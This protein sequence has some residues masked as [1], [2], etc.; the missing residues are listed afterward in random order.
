MTSESLRWI[1][2]EDSGGTAK[3]KDGKLNPTWNTSFRRA[4]KSLESRGRIGIVSR[5]LVSFEECVAHYPNKTLQV[6]ARNLRSDF[7]PVLQEWIDAEDGITPKYGTAANEEHHLK[8]LPKNE[9]DM[10]VRDWMNLEESI[11]P[12]YGSAPRAGSD[13][14]LR[15]ICKGRNLFL[16]SDISAHGSLAGLIGSACNGGSLPT[17]LNARLSAFSDRVVSRE[18]AAALE[19]K[20]LIH[21]LADVVRHG[22][23]GLR[24]RTLEYLHRQKKSEV[25]ALDGFED[26]HQGEFKPWN[27]PELR[28]IYPPSLTKLFDHSVLQKFDFVTLA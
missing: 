3:V 25:E 22:S 7:L 19:F 9:F 27:I 15:L 20:S 18:T 24:K 16:A 28:Y 26:K 23:C 14:L 8:Q 5:T 12:L 21:A 6:D 10:L 13:G 11:R 1:M 4:L 2:P 17:E